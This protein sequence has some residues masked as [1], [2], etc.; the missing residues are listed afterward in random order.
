M[1]VLAPFAY[2][3]FYLIVGLELNNA[4][5]TKYTVTPALFVPDSKY[6]TFSKTRDQELQLCI[7]GSFDQVKYMFVV[8]I[9]KMYS[10]MSLYIICF[11][12]SANN[13]ISSLVNCRVWGSL[14][15]SL[16]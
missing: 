6:Y 3:I 15:Q 7:K 2:T 10:K 16:P 14:P 13:V 11:G 1:T 8:T 5:F 9:L 4:T 12:F